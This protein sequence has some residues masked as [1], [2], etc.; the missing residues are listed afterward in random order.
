MISTIHTYFIF[1][2]I[3][4]SVRARW[5]PARRALGSG[6]RTQGNRNR[7]GGRLFR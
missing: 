7:G 6:V 1:T 5:Q 4:L 3:I 2:V